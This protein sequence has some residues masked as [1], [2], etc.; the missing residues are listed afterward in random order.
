MYLPSVKQY[1]N[2][3]QIIILNNNNNNRS[4][5][6]TKFKSNPQLYIVKNLL[7]SKLI[8]A[9]KNIVIRKKQYSEKHN[10]EANTTASEGSR[11]KS[12]SSPN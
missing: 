11:I 8:C 9:F 4:I 6:N 3:K 10:A 2:N 1:G 7:T 12:T 5:S